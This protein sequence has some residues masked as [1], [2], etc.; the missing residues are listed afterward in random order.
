MHGVEVV[1]IFIARELELALNDANEL[2]KT[3]QSDWETSNNQV[4]WL[5]KKIEEGD[6]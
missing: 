2:I 5:L 3:M 1:P 4:E 6:V